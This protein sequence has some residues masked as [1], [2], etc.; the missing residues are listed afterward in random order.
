MR[1]ILV[2]VWQGKLGPGQALNKLEDELIR[3]GPKFEKL[4]KNRD[5]VLYA[6]ESLGKKAITTTECEEEIIWALN[7]CR[8]CQT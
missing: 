4:R 3:D 1:S 2:Q 7:N 8:K 6:L 5:Q